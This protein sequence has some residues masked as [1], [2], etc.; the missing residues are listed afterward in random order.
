MRLNNYKSA[1]KSFKTKKQETQKLFHG[2]YIQDDHEGKNDW[3]FMLTDQ[4]TTNAEL[5]KR[6]VFW[7]QHLKTFFPNGLNE[8][9]ESCL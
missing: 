1:Q 3:Q 2:H 7:E 6:E 5:R 8:H 4:C 9:E